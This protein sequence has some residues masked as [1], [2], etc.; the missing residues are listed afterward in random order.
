MTLTTIKY[1][2]IALKIFN[3]YSNGLLDASLKIVKLG[4]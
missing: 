4:G 3:K 2:I 1:N